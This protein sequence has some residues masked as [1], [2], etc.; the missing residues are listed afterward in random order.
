MPRHSQKL[1][2]PGHGGHMLAARLDLPEADLLEQGEPRAY[3]LFAHCFTCSK[4]VFAASRIAGALAGRGIA[5]L[6]FDFTGLGASEGEFANTNFSSNKE[7]LLAAVAHLRAQFQAP[8][9]LVGHSL[10]GAAVLA[11]AGDIP[12]LQLTATIGAPFEAEHVT[13]NFGAKMDEI[14]ARGIAEVTLAGRRF[15]IKKQFL[16]DLAES[17]VNER[18]DKLR[19]PLLIFHAPLDETVS[20]DNARRIFER[21]HHPKSFISLADADHLLHNHADAAFVANIIAAWTDRYI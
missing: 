10:G 20:I 7:D 1:T 3:A 18:I 5:V 2:F 6:R 11:V 16:D 4:D 9:I 19:K 8:K 15:T 17:H 14:E 13:Q 21:A 12:E